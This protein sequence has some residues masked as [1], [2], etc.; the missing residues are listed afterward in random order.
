MNVVAGRVQTEATR[1]E[2][3]IR[4]GRTYG[5]SVLAQFFSDTFVC[6]CEPS[7]EETGLLVD[8]VQKVCQGFIGNGLLP[9]G[10]I[11]LGD[12]M[13]TEGG[14]LVGQA[15]VEAHKIETSI[16]KYPRV[17]VSD[18]ARRFLALRGP[19][20]LFGPTQ[21]RNDPW[22]GLSYLDLFPTWTPGRRTP[23]IH[24]E[25][26]DAQAM[27]EAAVKRDRRDV[28][29][30]TGVA[31]LTVRANR[32]WMRSYLA[33]IGREPADDGSVPS[34]PWHVRRQKSNDA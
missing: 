18:D 7:R 10:A 17:V 31:G 4:S 21:V 22:D 29:P 14:I 3:F 2:I 20:G 23:Y 24:D 1:K 12:L 6:S 13:H 5:T 30:R 8:H 25:I 32:Q 15:L 33:E 16:A 28:G 34:P 26:L 27:F 9:R 19:S 11:V